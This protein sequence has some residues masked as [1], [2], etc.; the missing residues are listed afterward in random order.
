MLNSPH[1]V[2]SGREARC[3]SLSGV[4][5]AGLI[6]WAVHAAPL[7]LAAASHAPGHRLHTPSRPVGVMSD[8]GFSVAALTITTPQA[9]P[10]VEDQLRVCVT[11]A[12]LAGLVRELLPTGTPVHVLMNPT[13]SEHGY[14]FTPEEL[15]VLA[16]SEVVILVGLGLEPRVSSFLADHPEG[17]QAVDIARELAI[18]GEAHCEH[19]HDHDHE[20]GAGGGDVD[21][22][23]HGHGVDPHLWLD[24]ALMKQAVP[25]MRA[26]VE[27]SLRER[28][29]TAW[30]ESG[31]LDA[32][33]AKLIARIDAL[34]AQLRTKLEAFR[35]APIVTHH[36]AFGRF[37]ERYGL[38][39]VR[40]LRPIESVEPSPRQIADL[41]RTAQAEG[42]RAIFVEPQFDDQ[43]ARRL[44]RNIKVPVGK[45]D[46]IG[47]EDWFALMERIAGSIV[48][49][50]SSP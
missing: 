8:V 28:G 33:E 7:V 40:V 18:E 21:A 43:L 37:A 6:G 27:R 20:H 47:D 44:A 29:Q 2:P 13:R 17:R 9:Q 32:A 22:H 31:G 15:A 19:E 48:D 35:N 50:L 49:T 42:I 24:P 26:A 39:I 12:P 36:N 23:D 10:G 30:I 25:A 45:L 5:A 46:P 16:R 4:L 3:A 38:R 34:D 1:S 14:E 41:V 11:I